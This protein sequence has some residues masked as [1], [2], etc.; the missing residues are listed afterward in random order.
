MQLICICDALSLFVSFC[1]IV[2]SSQLMISFFEWT[3]SPMMLTESIAS[4]NIDSDIRRLVDQPYVEGKGLSCACPS[5]PSTIFQEDPIEPK[6][7]I[8]F[9]AFL[10]DDSSPSAAVFSFSLKP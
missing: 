8:K 10:E 9:P 5:V 4:R 1:C 3:R 7:G 6:T 2:V